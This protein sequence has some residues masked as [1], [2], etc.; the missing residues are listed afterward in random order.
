M[1]HSAEPLE[2]NN[3]FKRFDDLVRSERYFT[4]TLLPLL[5]FHD[6]MNGLQQFFELVDKKASTEHDR[7]GTQ[8]PKGVPEYDFEDV[9]VI[10]EFH[11]ARDLLISS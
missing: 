6:K 7:S 1:E 4:A 5:L 9:E 2:L 8:G 3:K 11:I 10:T